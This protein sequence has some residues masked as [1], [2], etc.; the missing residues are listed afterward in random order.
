[1]RL[2]PEIAF[3]AS[4]RR[5]VPAGT[6]LGDQKRDEF[7]ATLLNI[8]G[9]VRHLWLPATGDIT[10]NT[11]TD[12]NARATTYGA[13]VAS[14]R[15]MQ[16]SG[17]GLTFDASAPV[18]TVPDAANLSFGDTLIDQ[19]FSV[20]AWLTITASAAIKEVLTKYDL[21]TG[22]TGLE[23]RFFVDADE[24]LNFVVYDDS[25]VASIGRLYNT[26]LASDGTVLFVAG[27]YNGTGAIP[28]IRL[29]SAAAVVDDTNVSAGTYVAM[30]N[31]AG[32]LRLGAQE[33]AAGAAGLI[34]NGN[35]YCVGL[36][37]KALSVDELWA[38]KAAG[39][40]FFDLAL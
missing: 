2:A 27:T 33:S 36:V 24:K 20:F 3:Q 4:P 21:T 11:G 35:L 39:N 29:Y 16:G 8:G 18:A 9:D 12:R 7:I 1:M 25:A 31:K 26:A 28:G 6:P 34:Y 13:T 23:Y 17:W 38:M 22:A 40:A 32:L 10:S 30:E 19:P 5:H 14:L 15:K 37:A